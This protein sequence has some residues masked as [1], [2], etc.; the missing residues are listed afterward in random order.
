VA[1]RSHGTRDIRGC[2]GSGP[3][4]PEDLAGE[5]SG[6]LARPPETATAFDGHQRGAA[7]NTQI[8]TGWDDPGDD[9]RE[10]GWVGTVREALAPWSAGS[11]YL[12]LLGDEGPDRVRAAFSPATWDRQ[13]VKR[14]YDPDNLFRHNHNIPPG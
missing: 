3:A 5:V 14:R 2:P 13:Q 12:N 6:R 1:G 10:A 7:Y 4:E 9:A 11:G 8:L